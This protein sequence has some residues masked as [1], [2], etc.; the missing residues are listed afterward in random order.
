MHHSKLTLVLCASDD[1][2]GAGGEV[3]G[4]LVLLAH[5]E[6]ALLVQALPTLQC[7]MGCTSGGESS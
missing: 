5:V 7:A 1:L 4:D 6:L 3:Q 2:L